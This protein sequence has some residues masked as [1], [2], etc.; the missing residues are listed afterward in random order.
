MTLTGKRVRLRAFESEDLQAEHAMMN[1]EETLRA[2]LRGIPFPTSMADEQQWLGGQSSYTRGEYQFA[3][4]NEDG[5]LIGR[6][7]PTK[8][9]WKN[10][11]GELGI[12]IAGRWRGQGYGSEAMALLCGFCFGEMNL[13]KLK[14]A[15][16]AS[17][18]AALRC[19]EANGFRHE[20]TLREEVFRGGRYVDVELLARFAEADM[21]EE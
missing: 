6:C 15:V 9:D 2:M 20:G 14:V 11:V 19:Y 4:E 5:E 16:L 13:R 7:G 3:V 21:T 12:V 1:E 10:R 18:T 8:V 17:N